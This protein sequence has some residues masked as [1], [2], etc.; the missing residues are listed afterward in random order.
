MAFDFGRVLGVESDGERSSEQLV[1]RRRGPHSDEIK[2]QPR[3]RLDR[4]GDR[5][6]RSQ[7]DATP[8]PSSSG[9]KVKT[10]AAISGDSEFAPLFVP[11]AS[12]ARRRSAGS[13]STPSMAHSAS[14]DPSLPAHVTGGGS[15]PNLRAAVVRERSVHHQGPCLSSIVPIST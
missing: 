14:D 9:A 7:S 2:P 11:L 3:L 6:A 1:R 5:A 4:T 8:C 10:G 13:L 15:P 12:G